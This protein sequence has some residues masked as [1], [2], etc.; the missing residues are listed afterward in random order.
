MPCLQSTN[1]HSFGGTCN[2][3]SPELPLKPAMQNVKITG[4]SR[5]LKLEFFVPL[6][7]NTSQKLKKSLPRLASSVL[8]IV[9]PY[10]S[11]A[12]FLWANFLF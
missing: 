6:P 12:H 1:S 8:V 3:K 4:N 5:I 2:D 11:L 10:C 9:I 7:Q